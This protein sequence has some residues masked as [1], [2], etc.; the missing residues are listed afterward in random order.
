MPRGFLNDSAAERREAAARAVEVRLDAT[1]RSAHHALAGLSGALQGLGPSPSPASVRPA[2]PR[3]GPAFPAR[4]AR[5]EL[6]PA[7]FK[8]GKA[9]VLI[10]AVGLMATAW[11]WLAAGG[12]RR[13]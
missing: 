8:P 11:V 10:A 9:V 1:R 12:Q 7:P 5:V 13:G 6:P 2:S 3:P 4:E